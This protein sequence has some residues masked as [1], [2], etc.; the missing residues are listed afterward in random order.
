MQSRKPLRQT[1][2]ERN[3][4]SLMCLTVQNPIRR[5]CISITEWRPFEW[6]ILMVSEFRIEMWEVRGAT[7]FEAHEDIYNKMPAN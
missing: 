7:R 5:A 1:P 4:R 2:V 6:L 3:E